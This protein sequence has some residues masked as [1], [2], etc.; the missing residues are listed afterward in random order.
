MDTLVSVIVPIYNVKCYLQKC[1]NSILKQT[2]KDLEII[3]VDDGSTDGSAELCDQ[4]QQLDERVVVI[5]KE[6]GGV[7]SARL[8]GIERAKGEYAITIDGDDW[9]EPDMIAALYAAAVEN[10]ADM[11]TSGFFREKDVTYD[12]AIDGIKEGIYKNYHEKKYLFNNLIVCGTSEEIGMYGSLCCKLIRSKLLKEA[13]LGLNTNIR[14]A[15]DAAVV[16]SCCIRAK[17]IVVTHH[18]F[19]HYFMRVGSA[20]HTN[21]LYYFRN[22]NELYVY[23]KKEFEQSKFKEILMKQLDI[24]MTKLVLLGLNHYSDLGDGAVIPYYDFDKTI[25][26]KGARVVL[27]GAGR[28]GKAYYKQICADKLY[29]LVGWLDREYLYYLEKG[30]EILP[31]EELSGLEYDYIILAFKHEQLARQIKEDIMRTYQVKSSKILWLT[32]ISVIDKYFLN[33]KE[34]KTGKRII[35]VV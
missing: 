5:H 17:T 16:Y 4:I 13:H 2:H 15:E 21:D 14:Y 19:Y 9:I 1:I 12:I 23:L 10:D 32:P 22:I 25:I 29:Q 27:Y 11:V 30:M 24:Y 18:I 8:A 20:V 31:P 28:V 3:L 26:D 7:V 34:C 35:E 33:E 6:N